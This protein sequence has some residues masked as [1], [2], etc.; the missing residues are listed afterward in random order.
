M[1]QDRSISALIT[2]KV[3]KVSLG[4]SHIS[5]NVDADWRGKLLIAI[6]NNS[7]KDIILAQGEALCTMVFIKNNSPSTKVGG[8][9]KES[10]RTDIIMKQFVNNSKIEQRYINRLKFFSYF[11]KISAISVFGGAGYYFFG[12]TAGFGAMAAIGIGI[13]GNINIRQM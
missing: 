6:Y 4:L 11:L 2:S 9:E 3:S 13:A 10:G 7:R 12:P 8:V 1:P 5:T